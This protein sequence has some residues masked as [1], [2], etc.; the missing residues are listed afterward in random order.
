MVTLVVLE[1][2]DHL[3]NLELLETKD[4][5][6]T[7]EAKV[8]LDKSDNRDHKVLREIEVYLDFLDL[9]VLLALTVNADQLYDNFFFT[10]A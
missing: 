4:R 5:K 2:Q 10:E 3:V 8:L 6:V 1:V 9:L 7:K